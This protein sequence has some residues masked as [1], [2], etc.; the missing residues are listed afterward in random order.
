MLAGMMLIS[1]FSLAASDDKNYACQ[2]QL[3]NC[4]GYIIKHV[5]LQRKGAGSSSWDTIKEFT[6]N[7]TSG[8]A[9]CV[10]AG[11]WTEVQNE[12]IVKSGVPALFM[13]RLDLG[14]MVWCR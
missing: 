14:L 7:I 10:D 3:K 13:R 9:W 2:L 5:V 4:G 12:A 1:S 11:Q 6:P 8:Y